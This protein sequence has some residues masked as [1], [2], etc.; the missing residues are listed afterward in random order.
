MSFYLK[1]EEQGKNRR[2]CFN[3]YYECI[4]RKEELRKKGIAV[5]YSESGKDITKKT[6][7]ERKKEI[8]TP[9]KKALDDFIKM[10]DKFTDFRHQ[11]HR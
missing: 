3:S 6:Y 11:K 7:S 9:G 10:C 5:E 8:N 2:E 1:Y 4:K